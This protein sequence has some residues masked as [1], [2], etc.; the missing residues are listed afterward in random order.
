MLSPHHFGYLSTL[1]AGEQAKAIMSCIIRKPVSGVPTTSGSNQ[2]VQLQKMVR[3]LKFQ[4]LEEEGLHYLCCKNEGTD[5][6]HIYH[7][8]DL[9]LCFPWTH[10]HKAGF[11]MTRLT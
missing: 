3:G 9:R 1:K 10:I 6:L 2:T 11:L 5:Q 7:A 8:A 4:I